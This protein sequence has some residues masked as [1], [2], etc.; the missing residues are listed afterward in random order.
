[1]LKVLEDPTL[2]K[3]ETIQHGFFTRH[4]GVSTHHYASLKRQI[5]L[6]STSADCAIV[7]LADEQAGVIGLAHAGWQGAQKGV[8]QATVDTYTNEKD[9]FSCRRALH[10]GEPDFGRQ[11]SCIYLL[12]FSKQMP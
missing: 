1:M 7:L 6:G 9:F 11:L 3:L 5:I 12:Y 8:I 10:T 2:K 4:G